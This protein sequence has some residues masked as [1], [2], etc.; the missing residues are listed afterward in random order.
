MS[1]PPGQTAQVALDLVCAPVQN[2]IT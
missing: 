2:Y 1:D